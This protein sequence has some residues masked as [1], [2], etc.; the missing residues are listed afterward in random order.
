LDGFILQAPDTF[1][2]FEIHVNNELHGQEE[3]TL[4]TNRFGFPPF[5]KSARR[6]S[7]CAQKQIMPESLQNKPIT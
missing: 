5:I 2:L 1:P 3:H 4:S 7:S 6:N